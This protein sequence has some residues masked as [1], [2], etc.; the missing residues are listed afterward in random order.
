MDAVLRSETADQ[1]AAR[2]ASALSRTRVPPGAPSTRSAT[3]SRRRLRNAAALSSALREADAS[4]PPCVS[5]DVKRDIARTWRRLMSNAHLSFQVCA[6]CARR[7]RDCVLHPASAYPHLSL[8]RKTD[9]HLPVVPTCTRHPSLEGLILHPKGVSVSP[10]GVPSVSLCLY[11]ARKLRKNQLPSVATANM[12]F[13]G[14]VPDVLKGLTIPEQTIIALV[15]PKLT[16]L[17][18]GMGGD[19]LARQRAIKGNVIS[20]SQNVSSIDDR[21]RQLPPHCSTMLSDLKVVFTGAVASHRADVSRILRVRPS[22]VLDALSWL[23]ANNMLYRDIAIDHAALQSYAGEL[24]VPEAFWQNIEESSDP[25]LLDEGGG[26]VVPTDE[27]SAD[28]LFPSG[29]VDASGFDEPASAQDMAAARSVL[30]GDANVDP[31]RVLHVPSATSPESFFHNPNLL[32]KLFPT[33]FPYGV[34]GFQSARPVPLSFAAQVK[35]LLLLDDD[36]F[37]SHQSFLFV[38]FNIIQRKLSLLSSSVTIQR[39]SSADLEMLV[40]ASKA[41]CEEGLEAIAHQRPS[42]NPRLAT[43]LR[44][45]RAV[46]R[47]VP[48]SPQSRLKLRNMIRGMIIRMGSSRH[49]PDH[50]SR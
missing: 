17:K 41:D 4:W 18:L 29:V 1:R 42:R 38:A 16:I 30:L 26:Y 27:V 19:P 24:E 8:L 2:L 44:K 36:R 46:S 48:G 47:V 31:D 39:C 20:F 14:E 49:L 25:R 22:V 37:Q 13:V 15:R 43:L 21:V 11:C 33:L 5:E 45:L 32:P 10:T 9:R 6:C 23:R 12:L 34:P 3:R 28:T 50:Q 40:S 7:L 35:A